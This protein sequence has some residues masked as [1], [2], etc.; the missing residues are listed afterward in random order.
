MALV[1]PKLCIYL[2]LMSLLLVSGCQTYPSHTPVRIQDAGASQNSSMR[3]E[4]EP[5]AEVDDAASSGAEIISNNV[6]TTP[7]VKLT[8]LIQE[9]NVL[10]SKAKWWEAIDLAERG[11]RLEPRN[12]GLYKILVVAYDS[13][14]DQKSA[15]GFAG[16][17]FRY[18][19]RGSSLCDFFRDYKDQ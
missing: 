11:L 2:T 3:K 8:S 19:Q 14:G 12:A 6:V 1:A 13:M 18:C 16:Q 9:A 17:G 7:V 10:L 5:Q 4:N 15:L